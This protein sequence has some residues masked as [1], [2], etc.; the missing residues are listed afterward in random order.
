VLVSSFRIGEK[1]EHNGERHGAEWEI[2][3]EAPSDKSFS[4]VFDMLSK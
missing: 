2:N 4:D 3:P 1:E